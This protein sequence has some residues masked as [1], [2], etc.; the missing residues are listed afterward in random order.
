MTR[1]F[2]VSPAFGNC[3]ANADFKKINTLHRSHDQVRKST[4]KSNMLGEKIVNEMGY[5]S[6]KHLIQQQ[7]KTKKFTKQKK[8]RIFLFFKKLNYSDELIALLCSTIS[9]T[10][11]NKLNEV[12]Q[13]KQLVL[14]QLHWKQQQK[15]KSFYKIETKKK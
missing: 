5:F 14:K 2:N 9:K 4:T 12:L 15:K 7:N 6:K 11:A 3:C 8:K 1:N 10:C 13:N